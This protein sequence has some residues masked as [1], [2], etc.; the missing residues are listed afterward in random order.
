MQIFKWQWSNK[1][2]WFGKTLWTHIIG[3]QPC[4]S[5]LEFTFFC[6][7]FF[8]KYTILTKVVHSC[9]GHYEGDII[10]GLFM[11]FECLTKTNKVSNFKF[12]ISLFAMLQRAYLIPTQTLAQCPWADGSTHWTQSQRDTTH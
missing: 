3:C 8:G 1:C 10:I 6:I 11:H 12:A 9:G 4:L 5:S 7:F 2:Q